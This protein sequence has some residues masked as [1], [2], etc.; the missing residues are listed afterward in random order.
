MWFRHAHVNQAGNFL[1]RILYVC[2]IF[3]PKVRHWSSFSFCEFVKSSRRCRIDE[4]V[5][6]ARSPVTDSTASQS[7]RQKSTL[8]GVKLDCPAVLI[9]Y[10]QGRERERERGR[11]RRAGERECRLCLNWYNRFHFYGLDFFC[12]F[13]F[14]CIQEI[15]PQT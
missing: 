7:Q 4:W 5:L 14:M 11:E 12:L 15:H 10:T 13:C 9:E 8:L 6:D 2:N 1:I 3:L